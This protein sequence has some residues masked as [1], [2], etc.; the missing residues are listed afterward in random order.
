MN[1]A[2]HSLPAL[3]FR[4]LSWVYFSVIGRFYFELTEKIK[5]I[6]S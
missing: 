5:L 4:V 6:R 3:D 1:V 2:A